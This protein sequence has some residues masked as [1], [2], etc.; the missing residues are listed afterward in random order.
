MAAKTAIS[1][2]IMM[3]P[4]TKSRRTSLRRTRSAAGSSGGSSSVPKAVMADPLEKLVLR[5]EPED[6]GARRDV[7]L[8]RRALGLSRSRLKALIQ[9]GRV[10]LDG[11]PLDDPN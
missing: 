11:K 5:V 10:A 7:V 6:A 8:A 1:P 9:G 2:S 3:P 4:E